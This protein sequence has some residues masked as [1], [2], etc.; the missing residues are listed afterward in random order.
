MEDA[1]LAVEF[2]ASALGFIFAPESKRFN[3]PENRDWI[4]NLQV[5]LPKVGVFTNQSVSEINK[6]AKFCNL[7]RIQYHGLINE[8][9]LSKFFVPFWQVLSPEKIASGAIPD[10]PKIEFYLVDSSIKGKTGGTGIPFDWQILK[11]VNL[12][13]PV[14]VAGGLSP[15]NVLSLLSVYPADFIDLSSGVE[16]SSGIKDAGKMRTLFEVLKG[17]R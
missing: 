3:P 11:N 14:I 5:N 2:G 10:H 13:K 1:E 4:R 15:E 7:D 8:S 6:I 12:P 17:K 9:E 16:Q